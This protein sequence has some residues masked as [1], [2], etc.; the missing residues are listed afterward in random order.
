MKPRFSKL[1]LT[2]LSAIATM[3]HADVTQLDEV[4]VTAARVAQPA[5]EV[6]GDVTVLTQK[7]IATQGNTSL[8]ELL[9]RQPGVQIT[10]NGGQGKSGGVFIRGAN[11]NQ[12]VVLIDGVRY[13]SAT[14]GQAALQ[15]IP[16]AQVDRIEILR[17]PAAS[18][19]GADAIGGVIQIFTKRGGKGATP[20]IEIGYGTQD[21]VEASASLAGG[22]EQTRYSIGL[23]HSKTDGVSALV[24]PKYQKFNSDDDGYENNSVS[25]NFSHQ[26]NAANEIGASLLIAK[27]ENHYDGA[28]ATKYYDYRDE[29]TNGSATVWSKNQFTSNWTSKIQAGSSVDDSYSYAPAKTPAL[30]ET[31]IKTRQNQLSWQNDVKV[32][33]GLLTLGL[34]TLAQDVSKTGGNYTVDHR[35]INSLLGG[36]LANLGDFTLQA[37]LRSDDN[38]QFDRQTTGT[39]GGSWQASDAFQLGASYGTGYQ[40]PTFNQLYWP[41]WGNPNLKP[42][43]SEGGEVFARYQ[44]NQLKLGATLFRNEVKDFILNDRNTVKNVEKVRLSGLT[45]TADWA[46][47]GLEAGF[48][49]D[50]LD[51]LDQ[52]NDRQLELRAKNAGV[53]YAGL[54]S[55]QWR[56]RAEV[57]AQGE[58][59]DDVWGAGRVTLAG[60]ALT[61]LVA[62]Y[63]VAKDWAVSARVNNVFDKDYT[64]V[65]DYSTVGLN[66]MLSVRWAPK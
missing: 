21:S 53:V 55:N 59:Y 43:E 23:A 34:E 5:R 6:V 31:R 11:S 62:E 52:K 64:Q 37:N 38:S 14:T 27:V 33:P 30:E 18:L 24:L 58:R 1:Y 50:Y 35:R 19:Y 15:H 4:V 26:F 12:T 63:Q 56:L 17:G 22:N 16:L 60:Y 7:E 57:Q 25:A 65:Y 42:Q 29:G 2:C 66:G 20:S 32:G 36:Y 48:S 10:S 39:L 9:A 54:S 44:T 45:L 47:D 51:A 3:A 46:K 40:A 61:N 13:G 28:Y 49:Y 8:P 41:N